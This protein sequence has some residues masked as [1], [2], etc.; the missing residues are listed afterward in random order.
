[1][2][3]AKSK[4]SIDF[5]GADPCFQFLLCSNDGWILAGSEKLR[6]PSEIKSDKMGQSKGNLPVFLNARY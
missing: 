5:N 4:A 6:V 1:M 2:S 3:H